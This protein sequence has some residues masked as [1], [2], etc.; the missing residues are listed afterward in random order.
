[1]ETQN[2]NRTNNM[3]TYS[4]LAFNKI[5][6]IVPINPN[7]KYFETLQLNVKTLYIDNNKTYYN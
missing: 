2:L 7:P 3:F 5:C 6:L 4:E 1:M